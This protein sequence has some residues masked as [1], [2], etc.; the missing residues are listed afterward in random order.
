[1]SFNIELPNI[2]GNT[3]SEQT[4]QLQS[5]LFQMVGQLNWALNTIDTASSTE[6][7]SSAIKFEQGEKIT[8]KEAVDT[9]N[10]I[11][12]LIIKSA[13]IVK[14][15]EETIMTDFN[16]TYFAGSDFGSYLEQTN[17][18]IEEN[19]KGVNEVYVNVQ[20][21]SGKVDGI[22]NETKE[23]NAYIKRG[24][25][26]YHDRLKKDVYG[27]AVGQTDNGAYKR[28]AWFIS[29]GLCLFDENDNEVAYVSQNKLYIRD[30]AFFGTVQFGEY[31]LDTSDGLAFT[32]IG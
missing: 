5:Y 23:T 6:F 26:G 31:K 20:T 11:K 10:S 30:A 24:Y 4:R 32:W 16:G 12:A 15:Y 18:S 21:V 28:Y 27:V 7:A 19:S 9:F 14:A 25:L 3:P 29:E 8:E 13:D 22:E 2:T 1:M 17:R